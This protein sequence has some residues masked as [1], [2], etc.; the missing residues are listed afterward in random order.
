[1]TE[2]S[3]MDD[4]IAKTDGLNELGTVASQPWSPELIMQL[5]YSILGFAS[6]ALL[7]CTILLWGKSVTSIG[8]LRIFGILCIVGLS[9]ILLITGFGKDQLTPI[10]GLFGAIAGYLLGKDS[11]K[12]DGSKTA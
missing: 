2:K 1:M 3:I 8:I 4:L 5:T 10:I 9:A 7:L 12:E 11:S 6:L